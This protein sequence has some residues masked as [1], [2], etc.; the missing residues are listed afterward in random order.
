MQLLQPTLWLQLLGLHRANGCRWMLQLRW[1]YESRASC[2]VQLCL[3][4]WQLRFRFWVR[5]LRWMLVQWS[6]WLR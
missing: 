6:V 5:I 2:M 1:H 4:R 3:R